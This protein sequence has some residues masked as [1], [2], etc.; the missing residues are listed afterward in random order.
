MGAP[1]AL[2]H[3]LGATCVKDYE[4]LCKQLK[5]DFLTLN[6]ISSP[7]PK[8]LCPEKENF[9]CS[10]ADEAVET[11]SCEEKLVF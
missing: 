11:Y 10:K 2:Y 9:I 6:L 7:H 5:A 1:A 3:R 4:V 8:L